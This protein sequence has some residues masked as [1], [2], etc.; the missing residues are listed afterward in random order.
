MSE[1]LMSTYARQNLAF[2]RGE[3]SYLYTADG[4]RY[5][6]FASGIAVTAL[7][8]SHP[9]LVAKLQE[10]VGK[11][12]HTSNLFQI[13]AQEELGA[14]LVAASFADK[15]FFCNSGAEACEGSVKIARKYFAAKG[16]PER[17]R[18]IT[19][20][21][22]FHGRTIAMLAAG[23]NKKYL[24]GF[25]HKADGFDQVPLNDL[26]AV[27]AA[28]GPE[29][30]AIMVEPI[31]GEGGIREVPSETLR[32][33]RQLC[34]ER[35]LLLIFDEVQT[36]MGRTGKLFAHELSDVTPDIMALAKGLG[37]GFP[38]AAILAT[39]RAASGIAPGTHG[40]T[41]GGNLLAMTAGN[42]VLD[43][44]LAPGFLDQVQQNGLRL[45]QQLAMIADRHPDIIEGVRG[46]GLLLAVK[47]RVPNGDLLNELVNQEMVT[48]TASENT[49]R[50]LPPLTV[51]DA[52]IGEAVRKLEAACVAL[53]AKLAPAET[54]KA[55]AA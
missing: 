55:G 53:E 43:V 15:A 11:L 48:V 9:H 52:E 29:T 46:Q 17:W 21:G 47:T 35:D 44:M 34:D 23:N 3:G 41:F 40:T 12:W 20:D 6:D 24:D 30:A 10:Q 51:S 13:P 37:G 50:L 7:G 49:L 28:I 2:E 14:R 39:A 38:V 26:E 54:A 32:A 42:A 45:R 25:G 31:Q 27:K 18:V 36:G 16:Q 4:R 22:A 19:F 1:A 33:L 8:H 5:L